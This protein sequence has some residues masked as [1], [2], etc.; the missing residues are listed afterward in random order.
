MKK[1]VTN[2][3]EWFNI[4]REDYYFRKD[5]NPYR[6]WVSEVVLQQT[7]ISAALQPLE[8]FFSYFPDVASLANAQEETVL[9]AFRGLGYYSRA[10]NLKKG[11]EYI[12]KYFNG[13]LPTESQKLLQIP[14]IGSYTAAAI[15]S[16]CFGEVIPVVDGNIKRILARLCRWSECQDNAGFAEQCSKFLLPL[17]QESNYAPG[18][19]NEAFMELGQKVCL[20]RPLCQQCPISSF[21]QGYMQGDA[22]AYPVKKEKVAKI[23]VLWNIYII[24]KD[25]QVLLQ[26]WR[27]FYFLKNQIS[28]PSCLEF[29]D[30]TLKSYSYLELGELLPQKRVSHAITNH[31][32]IL[33]PYLVKKF[34]ISEN[35]LKQDNCFWI[36]KNQVTS[37]L[38]ASALSKV[39]KNI[40]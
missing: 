4:V 19:L 21:C 24:L 14:S 30:K 23:N 27:D 18:D 2:L 1:L 7:R 22:I 34:D 25:N 8:R 37:Y 15:A 5:R 40:S 10:R 11:A 17:Y 9:Q 20:L 26:K 35:A 3:M 33:Q 38:V 6:V 13:V 29:K 28:F 36:D 12:C 16:I 39:W 31:K 32:I